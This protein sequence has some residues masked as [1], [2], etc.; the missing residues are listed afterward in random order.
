MYKASIARRKIERKKR[1]EP[2]RLFKKNIEEINQSIKEA[3]KNQMFYRS[4]PI[5]DD[6]DDN[7]IKKIKT[8]YESKG[9][10]VEETK[11]AWSNMVFIIYW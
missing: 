1:K 6:V 3:V 10:K 2:K 9:Y 8:Y 11:T 7:L 5:F 4:V